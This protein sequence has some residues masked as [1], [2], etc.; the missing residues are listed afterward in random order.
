[1]IEVELPDGTILQF[2][3][4]TSPEV[5]KSAIKKL[6]AAN[7]P[8]G[9][10]P[11]QRAKA[12]RE[13]TL[14][15]PSPERLAEQKAIDRRAEDRMILE[16]EPAASKFAAKFLQ[17]VPFVGEYLDEATGALGGKAA[18]ESVRAVQGAM[19]REY[20][21]TSTALQI[22]GGIAGSV[23]MAAAAAPAAV[24]N[25]PATLLGK[26]LAA[27]AAGAV[28]GGV[29]GVVSGYGVQGDRVENAKT[30]G[31]MGAGLGGAVGAAAPVLGA[32][33]KALAERI[34]GMD[35][36]T[37]AKTLGISDDAAR[38]LKPDLEALDFGAAQR[39]LQTAGPKAMLADAGQTTREALDAAITGGGKAARIGVDA[40]S[41]RAAEAGGRLGKIMDVIL[42][43]PKGVKAAS[44][45]ISERTAP[46]RAK[47][48]EL[49]YGTAINYADDTGRNI[50]EV[51]SRVDGPTLK[52]A[53]T[54]AND[55]MRAAGVKNMQILH[56]INDAGEIVFTKEMP[57]V[58]QLDEIKKGLDAIVR[59]ETDDITGK[60]S[61]KG[62]RAS[63]LAKDLRAAIGEAVPAYKTAVKLGG[64]KIAEEN[65]LN[66]GR[67]IFGTGYTRETVAEIMD[68][69]SVE[70]KDAA[71][72][73]I[74]EYID[75]TLARVRRS[76]DDPNVDTK[77]TLRLLNTLSSRD[78]RDKLAIVLGDAKADRLIKE[79]DA[80]G[81]QFG[82]RQ[83]IATGSAT[84]RREAR[85]R[86]MDELLAPGVVGNFAKGQPI[87]GLKSFMELVTRATPQADLARKQEVLADVARALTEIRGPQAE[88]ALK[89]IEKAVSGQPLKNEE[90]LRI[91]R[92]V[93]TTGALGGYQTGQKTLGDRFVPRDAY[94]RP[95]PAPEY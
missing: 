71:R 23:P 27:G 6:T 91:A 16:T 54:E 73:G 69:A 43:V 41:E 55:A 11:G 38:Y 30:R 79:I 31:I 20:P 35:V 46:A 36:V 47:A 34:K 42:G 33:I 18:M 53:I 49:A 74:R 13:G 61:S 44:K 65:A 40:V 19:D 39:S 78:A 9:M 89:L 1:M 64:D 45:S 90:A 85:S 62:R 14:P 72:Q 21:K 26:G 67:K 32:G 8:D 77:E 29:E 83:A 82:T 57:N 51:L 5:M 58:Q 63:L 81:K 3:E 37:I 66:M 76:V 7:G 48:Y 68:G 4:G 95:L 15:Q 86:A 17:G 28:A 25:A 60:I 94:G 50:E 80:A 56:E 87:A 70:A 75:D 24:A 10:T 2:P 84:G 92:L 52:A 22:A 59:A 12:A 93:A 88:A